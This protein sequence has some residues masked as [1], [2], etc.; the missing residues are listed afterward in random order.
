MN[1]EELKKR[2]DTCWRGNYINETIKVG[3]RILELEEDPQTALILSF[4]YQQLKDKGNALKYAKRH[5]TYKFKLQRMFLYFDMYCYDEGI[6]MCQE[7]LVDPDADELTKEFADRNYTSYLARQS[8]SEADIETLF[9]YIPRIK[10]DID[11]FGSTQDNLLNCVAFWKNVK[12]FE[13]LITKYGANPF[14]L[15]KYKD[16]ALTH[17]IENE[18]T[19]CFNLAMRLLDPNYIKHKVLCRNQMM[20]I[21]R[22]YKEKVREYIGTDDYEDIIEVEDENDI[23]CA[24]CGDFMESQA[25]MV[26]ED[27]K[28]KVKARLDTMNV[29]DDC[30]ICGDK[31]NKTTICKRCRDDVLR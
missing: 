2:L 1:L 4:C 16:S 18:S 25:L 3:K 29:L 23:E 12:G 31:P 8:F 21:L 24:R 14:L 13:L 5:N 9:A 6:Q 19:S 22:K 15:N 26:C 10:D 28:S 17:V 20:K 30:W 7:L 27:C 11:S